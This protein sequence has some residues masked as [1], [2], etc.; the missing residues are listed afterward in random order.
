[1]EGGGDVE[2]SRVMD[3]CRDVSSS[4][5][6]TLV[7]RRVSTRNIKI[8]FETGETRTTFIMTKG[9]EGQWETEETGRGIF[10]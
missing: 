1:M 5:S 9:L 8:E 2:P 3:V 7:G 10:S 4:Q 6:Y